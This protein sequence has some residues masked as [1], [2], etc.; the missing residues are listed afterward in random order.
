M[1]WFTLDE[2]IKTTDMT[3]RVTGGTGQHGGL[4]NAFHNYIGTDYVLWSQ[5]NNS[6]SYPF[7]L[8]Y[9]NG[10]LE[11]NATSPD[12]GMICL[13]IIPS[14]IGCI[15]FDV[16]F[17]PYPTSYQTQDF[18]LI[19]DYDSFSFLRLIKRQPP[20]IDDT[21]EHIKIDVDNPT[22]TFY[23]TMTSRC[24]WEMK[25]IKF[26]VVDVSPSGGAGSGYI[27]NSLVSN[28]K[29]VGYNVPT[30]SAES[31]K[32]ESINE[33][34]ES[35]V[36]GKPKIGNGHA[37]IK[38]ISEIKYWGFIEHMD[39]LDPAQR[40]EY[41]GLNKNYTP[42]TID[43]SSHSANYGSWSEHPIIQGNV[44]AM[45]K[46]DGTLDYYLNPNDYTKKADNTASDITDLSYNG[47]AFA[48]IPKHYKR[49]YIEG[50]DRY[51]YISMEKLSDEYKPIGFIG[52]NNHEYKGAW[53]PMFYGT[54]VTQ[55]GVPK[56]VSLASGYPTKDKSSDTQN[57]Y[58]T[59]FCSQAKFFGGAIMNVITD[60][61]T[62]FGKNSD[63]QAVFG[64]GNAK[65]YSSSGPNYGMKENAVVGGGQFYGTT[66]GYSLNKILHSIVLGT[67]NQ[68]QRD[69]YMIL[70]SGRLKV[71]PTYAYDPTGA[72]SRYIDTGIDYTSSYSDRWVYP[73]KSL[74]VPDFG[75]VFDTGPYSGSTTTGYADGFYYG[76]SGT[77]MFSRFNVCNGDRSAGPRAFYA[78]REASF[79]EW[80]IGASPFLLSDI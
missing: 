9:N 65:G 43:S 79:T 34:S 11:M 76:R 33:A 48:Y 54:D 63:I 44:P 41:I 13:P 55:N 37:R 45:I 46:S 19:L 40:V 72:D 25:N 23:F 49:E 24:C 15:E 6:Y 64:I 22:E 77:K 5:A 39:V 70:V 1:A 56:I 8:T 30:S 4:D 67:Y 61:L 80:A 53:I 51:V 17:K 26:Y 10:D 36:S 31:T 75:A 66:D 57:T 3:H 62:L 21:W 52:P 16:K 69:P 12:Y 28:K 71:C 58:M 42:I 14:N 29:M 32:T 59:N 35:P 27:G 50:N 20:T 38:L 2:L 60:L 68:W 7:Q 78:D 73:H 47:G 74:L 18:M